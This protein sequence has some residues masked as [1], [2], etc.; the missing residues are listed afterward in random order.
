MSSLSS[1]AEG[2]RSDAVSVGIGCL[3]ALTA[4][5]ESI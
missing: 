4:A 3:L 1:R 2:E 5:K